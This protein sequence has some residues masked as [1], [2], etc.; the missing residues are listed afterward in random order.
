MKIIQQLLISHVQVASNGLL[1]NF[2]GGFEGAVSLHH[3]PSP[4]LH[5]T[6]AFHPKKKFRAR[7]LWVDVAIKTVG[8]TI[9]KQLVSG[10]AYQFEGLEIG[11]SFEGIIMYILSCIYVQDP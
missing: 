7:V 11:D 1:M 10:R 5:S 2:L 9:Q 4:S 8:L 3:L 6:E